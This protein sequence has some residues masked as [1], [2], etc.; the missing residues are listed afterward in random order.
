[1]CNARGKKKTNTFLQCITSNTGE[2][3]LNTDYSKHVDTHLQMLEEKTHKKSIHIL[4]SSITQLI[5]RILPLH[6]TPPHPDTEIATLKQGGNF[7]SMNLRYIKQ[8]RLLKTPNKPEMMDLNTQI[9]PK[10]LGYLVSSICF[11]LPLL[12]L[13]HFFPPS[14]RDTPQRPILSEKIVAF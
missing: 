14:C 12:V 9:L 7:L 11:T 4:K 6:W 5:V 1:M 13:K 3:N 8:S 2:S 10:P